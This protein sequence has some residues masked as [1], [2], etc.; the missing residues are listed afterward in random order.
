MESD[1]IKVYLKEKKRSDYNTDFEDKVA[2]KVA[3]QFR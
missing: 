2:K 3:L 1:Y